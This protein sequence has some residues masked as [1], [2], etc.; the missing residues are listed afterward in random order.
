MIGKED[1]NLTPVKE[2]SWLRALR[3][4]SLTMRLV[5]SL[6]MGAIIGVAGGALFPPFTHIRELARLR[7]VGAIT[8]EDYEAR[9][10]EILSKL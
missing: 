3:A 2:A 9:K 6:F 7:D 5:I 8:R 4:L 1:P 10:R